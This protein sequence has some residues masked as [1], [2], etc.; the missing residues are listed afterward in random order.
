MAK[1]EHNA[2]LSTS[3]SSSVSLGLST[4]KALPRAPPPPPPPLKDVE[5]RQWRTPGAREELPPP[6]PRKDVAPKLS[7]RSSDY[8][9]AFCYVLVYLEVAW[10]IF[11]LLRMY[12]A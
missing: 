7:R 10:L 3:K 1:T 11:S 2:C 9:L 5:E 12:V 6:P 8:V 4:E